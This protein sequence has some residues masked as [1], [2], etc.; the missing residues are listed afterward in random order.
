MP[1]AGRLDAGDVVLPVE[2]GL[3]VAGAAVIPVRGLHRLVD[4]PPVDG[5]R[6]HPHWPLA[7]LLGV[8]VGER[9]A[10]TCPARVLRTCAPPPPGFLGPLHTDAGWGGTSLTNSHPVPS[11]PGLLLS[12]SLSEERPRSRT[13]QQVPTD[14]RVLFL[15][16]SSLLPELL[17]PVFCPPSSFSQIHISPDLPSPQT[18]HLPRP[19]ISPDLSSPLTSHLPYPPSPHAPSPRHPHLPRLPIMSPAPFIP[20]IFSIPLK[21]CISPHTT[22]HTTWHPGHYLFGFYFS[23]SS[24]ECQL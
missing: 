5:R 21:G 15:P 23:V 7:L 9:S 2:V 17:L 8:R 22:Y 3:H 19:L 6:Q 24:W 4:A 20:F 10:L 14:F 1:E 16:F 11:A 12:S 18:S 13:G